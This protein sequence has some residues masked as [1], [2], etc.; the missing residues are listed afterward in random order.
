M[1]VCCRRNDEEVK[2]MGQVLS[3]HPRNSA[4]AEQSATE[5]CDLPDFENLFLWNLIVRL[6]VQGFASVAQAISDSAAN[7]SGSPSGRRE[8]DGLVDLGLSL[9]AQGNGAKR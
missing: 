7:L 1:T 4:V 6:G 3:F 5:P 8:L 2:V 9:M